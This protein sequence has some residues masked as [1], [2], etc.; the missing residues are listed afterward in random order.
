MWIGI[1]DTDSRRGGCTT[2]LSNRIREAFPELTLA[3]PPSL[4]RLNPMVPWKTRGNGAVAMRFE[5]ALS[6]DEAYRRVESVVRTLCDLSDA[7]TNPGIVVARRPPPRSFYEAAVRRIVTR[8]EADAALAGCDARAG[9]FNG[10]LGVIG[11][12]AAVAWTPDANASWELVAYRARNRWG[13]PRAVDARS[14]ADMATAFPSTFDSYDFENDEVVMVPGSPCP[15][16]WGIRGDDPEDLPQAAARVRGEVPSERTL[17][18]TNHG[19]DD[20]LVSRRVA[21]IGTFESVRVAGRVTSRPENLPGGHVRFDL[22]DSTGTV[23][24]LAFEPTKGFRHVVR[25]LS[26]GDGI[27]ACGGVGPRRAIHL[28]KLC[29]Q[30]LAAPRPRAVENPRCPSCG[31]A[32]K[33][34]GALAP[35]RCR[36]CGVRIPRGAAVLAAAPRELAPGWYEVPA[37]ARRHLAMPLARATRRNLLPPAPALLAA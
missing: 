8:A 30:A 15:V 36:R 28:E 5:G 12:T 26:A 24:C 29:V 16:L 35:Y 7:D 20:H 2:Y 33:S 9:G 37:R 31:R 19:T 18:R 6:L 1:D 14:V 32:A 22:E 21:D 27:V 34:A 10:A 4:V 23:T 17:F 11:A 13:S 3:Q 25:K